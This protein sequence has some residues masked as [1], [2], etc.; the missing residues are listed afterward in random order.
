MLAAH[1][2]PTSVDESVDA[3]VADLVQSSQAVAEQDPK[4]EAIKEA[5]VEMSDQNKEAMENAETFGFGYYK[6]FYP[7]VYIPSYPVVHQYAY[8]VV[9]HYPGYVRYY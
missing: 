1:A 7:R 4:V 6:T 8:P 5:D 3:P 9:H 2:K